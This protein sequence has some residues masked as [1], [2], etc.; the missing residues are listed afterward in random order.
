[1]GC[2]SDLLV[3]TRLKSFSNLAASQFCFSRSIKSTTTLLHYD[4]C[5]VAWLLHCKVALLLRCEVALQSCVIVALQGCII[6]ALQLARLL[7]V[8]FSHVPGD[9]SLP[10]F[11]T[12]RILP[13][14]SMYTCISF[15]HDVIQHRGPT[16]AISIFPWMGISLNPT[17]HLKFCWLDLMC[18][19]DLKIW[20]DFDVIKCR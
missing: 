4:F 6:V 3:L 1:M 18:K 7:F 8:C 10:V 19:F 11:R 13:F 14:R 9:W 5:K 12:F 17:R 2:I 20:H 16:A 15:P